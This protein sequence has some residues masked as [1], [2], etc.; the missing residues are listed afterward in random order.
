MMCVGLSNCVRR[1]L[2]G[3]QTEDWQSDK[4]EVSLLEGMPVETILSNLEKAVK[5]V[6]SS[7]KCTFVDCSLISSVN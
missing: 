4:C 2:T 7:T 3:L 6:E 1:R 5:Y